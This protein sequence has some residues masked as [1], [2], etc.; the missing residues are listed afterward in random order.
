MRTATSILRLLAAAL[1]GTGAVCAAEPAAPAD[2]SVTNELLFKKRIRR[3]Y[4][5]QLIVEPSAQA[6]A[7]P[8]AERGASSTASPAASDLIRRGSADLP[9]T[10]TLAPPPIRPERARR[11]AKEDEDDW[12]LTPEER[13]ARELK[14]IS[15]EEDEGD[16]SESSDENWMARGLA[17]LEKERKTAREK[18][19]EDQRAER[20]AEQ[21]AEIMGRDLFAGL[22]ADPTTT[23]IFSGDDRAARSARPSLS[24]SAAPSTVT[25]S[26]EPAAR[27]EAPVAEPPRGGPRT[28]AVRTDAERTDAP[29]TPPGFSVESKAATDAPGTDTSRSRAGAASDSPSVGPQLFKWSSSS[30]SGFAGLPSS[31]GCTAGGS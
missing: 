9:T 31:L 2:G 20:E 23:A 22:R 17:T 30:G 29:A 3:R 28:T 15:G 16:T 21:I 25:A 7:A 18:A 5:S 1:I 12:M 24:T 10:R 14:R 6:P 8:V 11:P 19:E 26:R 27:T 13:L 4:E